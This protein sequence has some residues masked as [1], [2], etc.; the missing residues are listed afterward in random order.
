VPRHVYLFSGASAVGKTSALKALLPLLEEGGAAPCVCKIDCLKTGDGALFQRMR[1]PCVTGLSG[2]ICPD[3]FLVSNLPELWEWADRL[4]RDT[5]VIET[6]GLPP[7]FPGYGT[8]DSRMC[9]GLHRQL[10]GAGAAR[11]H[12]HPGGLCGAH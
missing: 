5:L 12:A 8:H 2:D 6:A 10:P 7:L 3:H 1:L 4:G 9:A 11:P